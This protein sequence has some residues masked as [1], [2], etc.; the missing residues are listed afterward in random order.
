MQTIRFAKDFKKLDNDNFA[1]IRLK[2]KYTEG[3]IYLIK[4]PTREFEAR[5]MAKEYQRFG[6]IPKEYIVRDTETDT[7]SSAMR[8]FTNFYTDI[9]TLDSIVV[10]LFFTKNIH[11]R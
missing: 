8:L 1:T 5:L 7:Y 11:R 10:N 3:E 4:T 2:D 6:D 9:F